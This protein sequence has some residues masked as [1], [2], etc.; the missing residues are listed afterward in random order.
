MGWIISF[1]LHW[2]LDTLPLWAASHLF[3]GIAFDSVGALLL[4][5]LLLGLVN[6]VNS[7]RARFLDVSLTFVTLGF[8]VLVINA[9]MLPVGCLACPWLPY[10]RLLDR[11]LGR[12]F[13][14][15]IQFHR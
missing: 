7:S 13:H 1:L 3:R 11:L 2:A 6:A 5:G 15:A 14:F 10:Q 4:S 9:L 12:A 8:F